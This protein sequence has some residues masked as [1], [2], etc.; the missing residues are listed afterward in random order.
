M[1]VGNMNHYEKVKEQRQKRGLNNDLNK[2]YQ[3]DIKDDKYLN[4]HIMNLENK[5]IYLV[6]RVYKE[7]SINGFGWYKVLLLNNE[8]SH[9]I[10]IYENI[11][12]DDLI[13]NEIINKNK[14]IF[15]IMYNNIY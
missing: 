12:N 14:K 5:K 1:F 8:N 13:I 15:K 7:Y 11:N 4:N 9:R 10:V 6:E 2:L 3:K